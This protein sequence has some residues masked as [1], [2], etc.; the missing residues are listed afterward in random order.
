[1]LREYDPSAQLTIAIGVP[2]AILFVVFP[3]FACPICSAETVRAP[4]G[5]DRQAI[6]LLGVRLVWSGRQL[7]TFNFRVNL[8]KTLDFSEKLF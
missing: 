4:A 6:S 1:M 2:E 3:A 8:S 5:A 7:K